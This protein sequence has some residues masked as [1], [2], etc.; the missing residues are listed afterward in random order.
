MS[1]YVNCGIDDHE[2]V[3][4]LADTGPELL[5]RAIEE[6]GIA[7]SRVPREQL[8]IA[9]SLDTYCP[10]GKFVP[11]RMLSNLR[12]TYLNQPHGCHGARLTAEMTWALR[13]LPGTELLIEYEG[14][15]N[16]MLKTYPLTTLCQYDTRK[17]NGAIIFELL[18]VH[19]IMI[20]HGQ[21]MRNPFYVP[22]AHSDEAKSRAR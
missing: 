9:T 7:P 4:Y 2:A 1:E 15:V 21:I 17:F 16:D 20:V 14:R 3:T 8:S 19:P 10:D 22:S 5:D 18:N 12:D 13:G 6:L 11:D